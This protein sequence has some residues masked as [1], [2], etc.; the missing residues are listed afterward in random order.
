[1]SRSCVDSFVSVENL[2]SGL[3]APRDGPALL[4]GNLADI[5][6]GIAKAGGNDAG[7]NAILKFNLSISHAVAVGVTPAALGHYSAL[8]Y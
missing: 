4:S 5:F 6:L 8:L 7:M 2:L 3:A 1:M